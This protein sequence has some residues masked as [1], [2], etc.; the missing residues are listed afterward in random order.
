MNLTA[1]WATDGWMA[2]NELEWLAERARYAAVIVE[3]GCWKGR[4]TL[5]LADNTAGTVYA[6]D[7][8][9]G[10]EGDPHLAEV[11]RVGG[12]DGLYQVFCRNMGER[13]GVTGNV[14]ILRMPAKDAAAY[15]QA[16][17][18]DLVFIDASHVYADVKRDIET[19]RPLVKAGGILSGHDYACP[20]HRGVQDA[21]DELFPAVNRA[22]L[23]IWW[24]QV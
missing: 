8:W 7:H 14:R 12:P 17:A 21:V 9:R 5:A 24:V 19:Y 2:D 1:A 10:T 16:E 18:A 4:S 23:S 6:I 13:H 11:S 20:S 15:F 22:G 3:V